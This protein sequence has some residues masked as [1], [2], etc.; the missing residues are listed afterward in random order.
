[1]NIILCTREEES[2]ELAHGAL[3]CTHDEAYLMHYR[4]VGSKNGIRRWQNEDGSLTPAGYIHYGIGQGNK[5]TKKVEKYEKKVEKATLDTAKKKVASDRAAV[6][7]LHL[8]NDFTRANAN[9]AAL[10]E[11]EASY[12]ENKLKLKVERLKQ[13]AEKQ[14]QKGLER[15]EKDKE[16]EKNSETLSDRFQAGY[17]PPEMRGKSKEEIKAWEQKEIQKF[18]EMSQEERRLSD[19]DS[20]LTKFDKLSKEDQHKTGQEV[21]SM[22]EAFGQDYD[23]LDHDHKKIADGLSDWVFS[24]ID[25]KSGNWNVGEYHDG[26]NGAKAYQKLNDEYDKLN[27]RTDEIKKEIGYRGDQYK[28]SGR[29]GV[30]A[31][32]NDKKREQESARLNKALQSDSFWR[33]LSKASAKAEKDLCGAVLQ[34]M[35]FPDTPENRSLIFAYV[36]LD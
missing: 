21:M 7:A 26:T 17:L 24:R 12:K 4:T 13:K 35:G 20:K 32:I 25:E 5:Y 29:Y 1:M 2:R 3:I 27:Q 8:P 36:F 30:I 33:E 23:E 34:D 14:E 16:R 15:A 18:N 22:L 31:Q 10:R 9:K 28:D 19:L 6:K 11:R